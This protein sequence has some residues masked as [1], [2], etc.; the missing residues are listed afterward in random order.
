MGRS[1]PRY[2][3]RVPGALRTHPSTP[4]RGVPRWV[5]EVVIE[6]AKMDLAPFYST[7]TMSQMWEV[8]RYYVSSCCKVPVI[9]NYRMVKVNLVF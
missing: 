4:R 3:P 1:A 6:G 8:W 9:C 2:P 5:L 7:A